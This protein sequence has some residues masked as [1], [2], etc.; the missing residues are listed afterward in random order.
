[1]H[2]S[3]VNGSFLREKEKKN[4]RVLHVRIIES[5]FSNFRYAV[6]DGTTQTK[7]GSLVPNGEGTGYVLVQ[8]GTYSFV[9]PEGVVVKMVYTADKDGFRV[10][11]F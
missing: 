4:L 8:K 5:V 9:T 3:K 10:E 6:S 11:A 7:Q 1:M 2:L